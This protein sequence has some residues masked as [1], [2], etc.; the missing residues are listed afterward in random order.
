LAPLVGD[1][2]YDYDNDNEKDN[3]KDKNQVML[4]SKSI[5]QNNDGVIR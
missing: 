3:N 1:H 5:D 4:P 2:D